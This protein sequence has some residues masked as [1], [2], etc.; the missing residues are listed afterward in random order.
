MSHYDTL[1]VA[2]D[3]TAAEIK[4][5]YRKLA[6]KHH[7][8]RD[9][10]DHDTMAQI[11]RAYET[12]SNP[13]KRKRYDASGEDGPAPK[14]I[15]ESATEAVMQ[16][17]TQMVDSDFDGNI[18]AELN[19]HFRKML[20]KMT[21][22]NTACEAKIAKL[23]KRRAKIKAK[24]G[25]VNFMHQIIDEAIGKLKQRIEG[26]KQQVPLCEM[27]LAIVADFTDESS[28]VKADDDMFGVML[29]ILESQRGGKRGGAYGF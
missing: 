26:N 25:V 15:E 14:S 2:R 19:S 6:S 22:Q 28:V 4:R 13:E 27:A 18:V 29:Q 24:E 21:A 1:G 5:A 7:T 3:A 8:D 9:H 11:N 10:G 16:V 12:L 23:L 17:M 20:S